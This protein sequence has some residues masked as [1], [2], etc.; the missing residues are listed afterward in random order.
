VVHVDQESNPPFKITY[1]APTFGAFLM[2]LTSEED[3]EEE[4]E[5]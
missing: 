3:F 5:E 4:E 2:G 1:L